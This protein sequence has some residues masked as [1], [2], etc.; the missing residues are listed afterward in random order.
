MAKDKKV[1]AKPK[2]KAVEAKGERKPRVSSA[3]HAIR[4]ALG[5]GTEPEAIV[6][7]VQKKFP[8]RKITLGLVNW[9]AQGSKAAGKRKAA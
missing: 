5:E 2:G 7:Q 3:S 8:D 6:K 9:I 1:K 4:E